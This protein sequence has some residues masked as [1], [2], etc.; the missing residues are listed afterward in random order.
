MKTQTAVDFWL[1]SKRGCFGGWCCMEALILESVAIT[2]VVSTEMLKSTNLGM[3]WALS[4]KVK[5]FL[6]GNS[7][8][9]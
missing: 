1:G 2:V 7:Q 3:G 8:G 4:P 9:L 6:T 5:A